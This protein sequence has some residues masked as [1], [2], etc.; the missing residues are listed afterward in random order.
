MAIRNIRRYLSAV[1]EE[2]R[3]ACRDGFAN[4]YEAKKALWHAAIV[5]F[6]TA[7]DPEPYLDELRDI[8]LDTGLRPTRIET[9][10]HSAER[11]AR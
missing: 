4:E 8:A 1:I 2:Y 6:R 9:T 10:I 3:K 11:Q 5:I 7:D